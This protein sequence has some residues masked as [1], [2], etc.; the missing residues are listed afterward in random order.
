MNKDD[1]TARSEAPN[2]V[3]IVLDDLG[4]A[5]LGC[6][7]SDIQTPAIDRLARNGLR[8]NRFHVTGLCSPTRACLL[9]GHNHHSVGM[10]FLADIP[11]AHP[12]YTGKIP[13]STPTLP[14]VL[15]DSG[16]STMAVGKWHLAPRGERTSAGPFTRW[17]W[18]SSAITAFC[19]ATPI[20][21]I[22]NWFATTHTSMHLMYAPLGT[23]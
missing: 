16:W 15:R 5:Q 10:G 19:S 23:T 3:M 18:G 20:T 7:G 6:Y 4:Y 8:Y 1:V 14:R 22:R 17:G 21:G 9:T 12:G 13:A 2:V 11:T